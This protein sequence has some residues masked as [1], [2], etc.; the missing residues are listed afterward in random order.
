MVGIVSAGVHIPLFRLSREEIARAW[1]GRGGAGEK[2]V[3]GYD[4]DAV[5]MAVAAAEDAMKGLRRPAEGLFFAS[6][7]SPYKEKLAATI[8]ATALDLPRTCRTADYADSLR[9]PAIA[10]SAAVDAVKSGAAKNIV[11]AAADCR[12]G[13]ARSKFEQELGDGAAAVVIGDED[14]IA[15][16]DGSYSIYNEMFDVWRT[17]QDAYVRSAEER[18]IISE[19]YSKTMAEVVAGLLKKQGLAPKDITRIV[20]Y[21]PDARTHAA[22]AKTM[23]FDPKT[24][25][26][27][28][29]F[30]SIGNTGA[31]AALLML[32]A[33]LEEAKPGDKILFAAYGEGAD[34]FLLTA[35]E[36]ITKAPGRTRINGMIARKSPVAYERYATWRGLITPEAAKLGGEVA[37]S[38]AVLWR[39]RRAVLALYG[40]K[41]KHCGTPQYPMTRI[42]AVCQS[43]DSFEDY[44]FADKTAK[45]FTYAID[46]LAITENPPGVN[47]FID[48]DG[49]GRMLTEITDCDPK[50]VNVG[51][52]VEMTFRRFSATGGFMNYSWKARPVQG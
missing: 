3:A 25:A 23:G 6:T 22:L 45:V 8:M 52:P 4:E 2:A 1:G 32:A 36:N 30:A 40:V 47:A 50:A 14:V 46:Y 35:T 5:T 34:A 15:T 27:D 11:I 17:N 18:L 21:A 42:C 49:G 33:A 39:D 9:A 7:T 48:F 19:G 13:A 24:Q 44:R 26:Q 51:M 37:T 10:I 28:T 41:C 16:I 38:L 43:K 12:L 29:L 20:F 31:P